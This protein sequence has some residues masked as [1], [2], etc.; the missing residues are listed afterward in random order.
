MDFK[1]VIERINYLYHKSQ[2]EELTEDEKK[3][4]KELKAYYIEVMKN[5]VRAQLNNVLKADKQ[6]KDNYKN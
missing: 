1:K 3:E 4:Q 6:N 2:E 5:N